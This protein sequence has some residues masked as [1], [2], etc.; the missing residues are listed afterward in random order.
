MSLQF[1]PGRRMAIH[2]LG[3]LTAM[4]VVPVWAQNG[5]VEGAGRALTVVQVADTSAGQIE[6]SKDF[7]VGSRVA[8]QDINA[9]GGV[10][11]RQVQHKTVEVDGSDAS[12]RLALDTFRSQAGVLAFVGTVGGRVAARLTELLRH[13]APD[14]PH[15]APWLQNTQL[16]AGDNTFPIFASRQDQISHAVRTLSLAGVSELGAVYAS[17]AEHTD[18]H[19]DVQRT[20]TT[21]GMRLITYGPSADLQKLAQSLTPQSPRI[22]I[23]LGGTP[24]LLQFSQGIEKQA[25]MRYVIAMSDVNLQTLSQAGMSRQVPVI[26]TQVVPLVNTSS[27]VVRAYRSSLSR[28]F[29][30]PPTPQGLA[31]FIAS[32]Y[33]FETLQSL[34]GGVTRASLMAALQRR[35]SA[36]LGGFRIELDGKRRSGSFVTQSMLSHDGRIVG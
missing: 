18:Y 32:R 36:E 7:V 2:C 17:P 22:L 16:N 14:I 10:R 29:D 34:E 8:W 24:E 27:A 31:G 30:E 4:G 33:V 23:F 20:A 26:A 3:G 28:L 19:Q 6:V 11:G 25:A 5:K 12:L 13:E 35:S 21:L 9:S 15:I 1:N